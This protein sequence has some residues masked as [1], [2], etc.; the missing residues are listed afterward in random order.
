MKLVPLATAL[1]LVAVAHTSAAV[2]RSE[3]SK[4]NAVGSIA[5]Q[6]LRHHEIKGSEPSRHHASDVI[7]R[8]DDKSKVEDKPKI[9]DKAK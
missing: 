5:N 6:G 1:C 7:R 8:H 9:D 4:A 2:D 3:D